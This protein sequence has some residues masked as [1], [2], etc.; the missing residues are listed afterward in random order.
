LAV[1]LPFL[2]FIFVISVDWARVFYY[3]MIID[4]CARNG[5][6]YASDPLAAAQSPYTSVTQAALADAGNLNPQPTVSSTNGVDKDKNP[7]TEVNVSWTFSTVTNYPGVP[8]ANTLSRT[9]RVRVA[10]TTPN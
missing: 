8:N 4:N 2:A 1:L 7:Y 10:P 6:L 3:S 5:A 9:V